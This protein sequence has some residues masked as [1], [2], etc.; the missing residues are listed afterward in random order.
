MLLAFTLSMP[1]VSSWDGCWSGEGRI[2]AKVRPVRKS[3]AAVEQAN[4]A[5]GSHGYSFG[6]GWYARVSVEVVDAK[7]ARK[8][9]K[10]SAGFCGYDWMIDSILRRGSIEAPS[11]R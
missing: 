9:R 1:G 8:L 7:K 5:L 10:R 2:Y 4:R 6:D 3:Q 11:G